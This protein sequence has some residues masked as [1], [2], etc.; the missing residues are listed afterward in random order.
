[1]FEFP[2]FAI[3]AW[4]AKSTDGFDDPPNKPISGKVV[5]LPVLAVVEQVDEGLGVACRRR[6]VHRAQTTV[7]PQDG[8][9]LVLWKF[10]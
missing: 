4:V 9:G 2:L 3:Y 1:M 10:R 8:V 6:V 5:N 7:V